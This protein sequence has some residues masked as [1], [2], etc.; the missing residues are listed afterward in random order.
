MTNH[1]PFIHLDLHSSSHVFPRQD[2]VQR[3]L[4]SSYSGT[5]KVLKRLSKTFIIDHRGKRQCVSKD[6][7]KPAYLAR[8][9]AFVQIKRNDSIEDIAK[10]PPSSTAL[11]RRRTRRRVHF[12]GHL[13]DFFV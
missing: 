4:Q 5:H 3:P 13:K 8:D 9:E 11:V 10:I 7:W 6:R 12:L 1:K 2:A